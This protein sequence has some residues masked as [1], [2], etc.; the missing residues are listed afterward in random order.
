MSRARANPYGSAT[1]AA[2][3]PPEASP[4]KLCHPYGIC[5]ARRPSE[6]DIHH[7]A[8][9][10]PKLGHLVARSDRDPHMI[11]HRRPGAA[12]GH[13]FADQGREDLAAW[14]V[15]VDHQHVR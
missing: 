13:L 6:S 14:P 11:G 1:S 10:S 2:M 3:K 9:G 12:D 15:D 4:T 7:A 5:P 8:E